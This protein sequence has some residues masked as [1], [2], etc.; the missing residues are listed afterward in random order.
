MMNIINDISD[1]RK[2]RRKH[3]ANLE[4]SGTQEFFT[5]KFLCDKMLDKVPEEDWKDITKTFLDP[6]CGN[7]NFLVNTYERKL[8]WCNSVNDSLIALNSIWGTELMEDNTDECRN[9]LYLL[10]KYFCDK[11]NLTEE[12]FNSANSKCN[13]ILK[14]NIV[15]TDTFK[16]DYESWKLLEPEKKQLPLF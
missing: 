3:N 16:W 11:Q 10:F 4:I 7:G 9:R 12:Q 5:P 2:E 14:H 8:K 6:T 15:C 1:K 13:E